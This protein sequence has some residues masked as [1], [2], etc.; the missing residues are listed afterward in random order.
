MEQ[1]SAKPGAATQPDNRFKV[2]GTV[3]GDLQQ[4]LAGVPVRAFD[5]D[6]RSEQLLGETKTNPQGYYEI[7]YTLQQFAITDLQAAD[8][9]VRTYTPN[10]TVQ[11][12]SSVYYNAPQSLQVD[13]NLSARP[14]TGPSDF[15]RMQTA[16]RPFIGELQLSFL[17]ENDK[18][19]DISFLTNKTGLQ[20]S[21]IE[22]LI[23]AF[24]FNQQTQI[25]AAVFYGLLRE[26][27][28]G[29]SSTNVVSNFAETAF[30]AKMAYAFDTIMRSNI[31]VL[32]NALQKA[33]SA[34]IVPYS[35]TPQLQRIRELLLRQMMAYS[36]QHPVTDSAQ[37]LFQKTQLSGFTDQQIKAFRDYYA[38]YK[39]LEDDLWKTLSA[40]DDP[41]NPSTGL[42]T[43]FELFSLSNQSIALT[44]YLLSNQNTTR[45]TNVSSLVQNS[46]LDWERIITKT[47]VEP[48]T[49][50]PGA[51]REERIKN[52]AN[53]LESNFNQRFS[54]QAFAFKL[55]SDDRTVV[56][57]KDEITQLLQSHDAFDLRTTSV[58]QFAQQHA[59]T[60]TANDQVLNSLR[61]V[62]RVYR[63]APT[64]EA[65]NTLLNDNLTSAA[66][67]YRTGKD[68]FIRRYSP[69]LGE[70]QAKQVYEKATQVHAQSLA[71]AVNLKSLSDASHLAVFPDYKK[72]L[73]ALMV[74]VPNVDT[75]FGNT[76]FCECDECRSVYGAAAY[77]TDTLHYLDERASDTPGISVKDLLLYRRP[78]IGDIDLTCANTNTQVPYI[79]IACELMEDYIQK[80]TVNLNTSFLAKLNKG[81]IDNSLYTEIKTRFTAAGLSYVSDLLTSQAAVTDKYTVS[82]YNGTT[83]VAADHWVIRDSLVTLKATDKGAGGIEVLL[84]HQTLLDSTEI[85]ANPEYINVPVYNKLKTATRPFSLPYDLFETEGEQ[86]L[87]KAGVAKAD[88][89]KA[90][91]KQ[92][93]LTGPP[94]DTDLDYAYAY[95]KVQEGERDLIFKEDLV[96]QSAYWGTLA[97]GTTAVV[98]DF[99]QASKLDYD[100]V[101]SLINLTYINPTKDTLIEHDDLSCDTTKQH[102]TNLSP[103]KFDR[104]HRF[105]R[106]WKKTT[107]PMEEVDAVVMSP[108]IGNNTIT[109][110]LAYQLANF[111]QLQTLWSL[112]TFQLLSFYQD[113]DTLQT[114]NLYDQLFQNRSIANPVN[115]DFSVANV[116]AGA[117]AINDVHKSVITAAVGLMPDDLDL[118]IGQTDGKLSLNNLSYFYRSYLLSQALSVSI[119]DELKLLD[120]ININPF[121]DPATTY[122]FYRKFRTLIAS[123]FS[124]AELDYVLRQQD[125]G[126]G[127]LVPTT[128]AITSALSLLQTALL[129]LRTTTAVAP[130]P[131]GVLLSRWLAD[132]VLNWDPSF[133]GKVLD[134]LNTS[135]DDEYGQKIDNNTTFLLNLRVHYNVPSVVADLSALPGGLLFPN[136]L[137]SQISYDSNNRQLIFRGYMTAADQAALLGLSGD[138]AYQ[139]AINQLFAAAQLTDNNSAN[140]FFAS[141]ADINALKAITVAANGDAATAM[142][143]A[144]FLNVIAPVYTSLKQQSLLA[145]QITS[146]FKVANTVAAQ[147]L[148][149]ISSVYTDLTND[150]FV[151]KKFALTPANYAAQFNQ[152]LRLQKIGFIVNKLK[153]S[154][155]DLAWQLVHAAD[156]DSLDYLSLPLT[157]V[158]GPV[159]T[160][161]QFETL[162][163]LLKFEQHYPDKV[164]DASAIPPATIS[165]YKVL[166]D[167]IDAEPVGTIEAD[168]VTLTGWSA[169]DLK[170]LVE[171]PNSLNLQSPNDFK[172]P[173]ILMQLHQ[174]F[175]DLKQ[176]N[177][178]ADDAIAWTKPSLTYDDAVKIKQTLKAQYSDDE[179]PGVTQPLQDALREQKRDALIAYLLTN[180]GT[181]TWKTDAD[182][183]SYFLLDVEMCA[184]QPTSR[185]VQA[186]NSVQLFVQRCY[187]KLEDNITVDAAVDSDWNEWQWMKYFRLWQA[188]YK[189]FLY[190]ENWIEPELLPVKSPFFEDLENDLL[191]N[192]VTETNVEDA[193]M[194][195]LEKLDSVARLEVKAM[196][197][198]DASKSLYVFARTYGGDPKTYYF[199]QLIEERRWTPW[200]KI[201]LDIHSN[202]IVPVVYNH[203]LY[204]FWAT[205][206][207]RSDDPSDSDLTIPKPSSPGVY[208]PPS[209]PSKYWQIQLSYSEYKNGKWSPKKIS[210][211][212]DTG[213]ITAYE[214]S[215]PDQENFLFAALDLPQIDIKAIL[216]QYRRD[217]NTKPLINALTQ[218]I[219]NALVQNGNLYINCYYQQTEEQINGGSIKTYYQYVDSFQLDPCHGYPVVVSRPVAIKPWIFDR[220]SFVNMLDVEGVESPNNALSLNGAAI[221]SETPGTF[222]NLVPLQMS[223]IDRF[224]NILYQL[225]TQNNFAALRENVPV[226]SL[227]TFMSYFYQDANRTYY[228]RPEITDND[229]FEFLYQDLEKLLLAY[230]EQNKAQLQEIFSSIP[231]NSK[232]YFMHHYFNFFHPLACYFMRQLFTKGID[233]LMSRTTQL[234]GDVAYDPSPNKFNFQSYYKATP[235][236]YSDALEP[237]TYPNGVVDQF[238]GYPKD[239]VD[240]DIQSGYA[241]YNWELFF[242][243]PL[244][245]AERLSQ[246]QQFEDAD[247]WFKYIFN[248]TDA[249]AYPA[250]DKFWV[251]KPF[252]INVNDKYTQQRI[253]N[254]LKGVDA[255]DL[256]LIKDVKDWRN[257]PF[258]PH[259]IAEYRTVAYQKTVVM[260]YVDHLIAWGDYLFT[261]DTMESVNEAT[262]LYILASQILGPKPQIIPTS[263]EQP[264]DNYFQLE[265]KLDT[266]SDAL[267][268][269][270]NLMPLQKITGYNG[271]KPN[272]GMP[273]LKTLYFGL[274]V[275]DNLLTYWDTVA[276]RLYKIRHCLNIEGVFAPLALFAPPIDPGLLVRAAAAGLDL[277]SILNDLNSP[278]PFYRFNVMLQKATELT[279]EV[280]SLGASML[281]ALEKKDAEALAL[282][283][284]SQEISVL[285]AVMAVK[286]QQVNEAQATLDNLQKQQELTTIRRDYY[287]GL[288]SAGLNQQETI[289]L[290]L[291][292]ASTVIDVG[293]AAGYTLAGGLKLIPDF[294]IGASGF[295]GSPHAVVQ[296]GGKSFGD[297]AED[298][299]R[300]LSSIATGLDKAASLASTVGSYARRTQDWQN[301]L[302]L[303]SKELEQLDKQILAQQIRLA[304]ANKDVENQQLQIDN[305][306]QT[307]E[308]MHSKFTNI[309]LYNWMITRL[310][311]VYFQAYNLAYSTGKKAENCFRYE[312]GLTASSYINFGYWNS[313][314]KGLLS[315]EQL[316]YDLKKLEMAYYEQNKREYELTKHISLAQLDGVALLKLKTNGDCWINL[317]EELFDLDYPGHYMR[318][319]KSV[320]VTI[321]C[322]AGPYTNIS[323][324]LTLNKNS[325]RM[326]ADAAGTYARKQVSGIPADDK[327]FRDAVAGVQTIATSSAQND[328]GLFEFNFRDERYLPF[329]GAG[330]ISLWRLQLPAAVQ[331]FDYKTISDVIVHVRYTAREGG[332]Q[333]RTNAVTNLTTVLQ[334]GSLLVS[335]KDKGLFR[336]FSVR[337]EF[338]TEWYAFQNPV[339]AADDQVL[340]L[341]LTPDRFPY[342]ATLKNIKINAVELV[343]DT[344]ESPVNLQMKSPAAVSIANTLASGTYANLMSKQYAFSNQATGAW[345]VVNSHTNNRL[346]RDNTK[347]LI[348]IVHYELT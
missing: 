38:Q 184:C 99:E 232:L 16:V 318:R 262:Q 325:V 18:V 281:S 337:T 44:A 124:V 106:L 249:S 50:T 167:A 240:F 149:S 300:T 170:K 80:P 217:G 82:Q 272:P 92:H 169:T 29:S 83:D 288:I 341:N 116:T 186:T 17:T 132:P 301:Q 303:A 207:E 267:V 295:G 56:P 177:V 212:D 164:L 324:T 312:L 123:G 257:N 35:L 7:Y 133:I 5:K 263:Y 146:W 306:Q 26:N 78:D 142:R 127:A 234:K 237:V 334:N 176:L 287:Q 71:L 242:H 84:L 52:Y 60:F 166:Q 23:M 25:D 231:K 182:L 223:F 130:D 239:D 245:I 326:N 4:P 322:V 100:G 22:L 24:H 85:S 346:N 347:D 8:V 86:Y 6:I 304:I 339:A 229:G 291:N 189:V 13:I 192:E 340:N 108:V 331:Q 174:C 261:Q 330:A 247:K 91:S 175:T 315:G 206:T 95:L 298:L 79:D 163:N 297:S 201:D 121:A 138:A 286:N 273:A 299:V 75:L 140:I 54:T 104:M 117:L 39:G 65:V 151:N 103:Q 343:M 90:F 145:T 345:Q 197:Y 228:V 136:D 31:D 34:N 309:D 112:S 335:Q 161:A 215:Y 183:Y 283:R 3:R 191:Q 209:R 214:N 37:A 253:D 172:S 96:N 32:M 28:A 305:A 236:V 321:P 66:K 233:G 126:T 342:F 265:Q 2:F 320:S 113:I 208:P 154:A 213:I 205:F 310:S 225:Y 98:N 21:K 20:R 118:L 51:T 277:G 14:Y 125:D 259:Y 42:Q 46:A 101:L 269:I 329:E 187:L 194:R 97:A 115:T 63:L 211:N 45:T 110:A 11:K 105:L 196:W 235:V 275:N 195:Y 59:Q 241:L 280:K 296:T 251:T 332:E 270:E 338:P 289:A 260:K 144:T 204:L 73:K 319:I 302:K 274:P 307:D 153:L 165:V 9:L 81:T 244:M 131:Q 41:Q 77:L 156:I 147:L 327:R 155:S 114:D 107:L 158:A 216:E 313:L 279:N 15:E 173:A 282:L 150:D 308:L 317:P 119:A 294:V 238:P 30:E 168:L 314:K 200:E 258:Q 27:I 266:L 220:S 64:Y 111:V 284:S 323:C 89:I 12:E 94:S 40:H 243:A 70:K 224:V 72:A 246:N 256:A 188:N 36:Q 203:R 333:L 19:S 227:G 210:N 1:L 122:Q 143:F 171:A 348:I 328:S 157:A 162:I 47:E 135:D 141:N 58:G 202:H 43:A 179:W 271:V 152:Y 120:L 57:H 137:I 276:D 268:E 76:D 69:Q 109:P 74:E 68:N 10:G 53:Q 293:I 181:Q 336:L 62:Q 222:N 344:S 292:T 255:G 61:K 148:T 316:M 180:P 88:L 160:F 49:G 219:E 278:L 290:A 67:I 102:L 55:Q 198:D 87:Q 185:I 264:I 33:I 159:T 230:L 193:F 248:P 48:P 134:I 254:I 129:Q 226:A 93:D 199:R 285:K 178:T 190:P 311:T 218:G 221:L 128:T 252:F 139:T 250:P